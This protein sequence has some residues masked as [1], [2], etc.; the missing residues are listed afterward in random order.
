[1]LDEIIVEVIRKVD[2]D[3]NI[4]IDIAEFSRIQEI[5][6]DT[7]YINLV[8]ASLSEIGIIHYYIDES[9]SNEYCY[10]LGFEYTQGPAIFSIIH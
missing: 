5:T 1:M 4:L 6:V 7:D 3:C 8:R 9:E 2:A 10:T